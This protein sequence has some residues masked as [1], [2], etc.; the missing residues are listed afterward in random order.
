MAWI[1]R[2]QRKKALIVGQNKSVI[3]IPFQFDR[4]RIHPF[5]ARQQKKKRLTIYAY[6]SV[7]TTQKKTRKKIQKKNS[8]IKQNKKTTKFISSFRSSFYVCAPLLFLYTHT[9]CV[10]NKNI[11][12]AFMQI[13]LAA[14]R[15]TQGS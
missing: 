7:N 14:V 6:I 15:C 1:R 12:A 10:Y 5:P 8:R 13:W 11:R 9:K 2:Y 3:L 4:A